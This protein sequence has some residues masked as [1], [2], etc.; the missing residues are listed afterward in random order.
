MPA[1]ALAPSLPT[2]RS[3]AGP[4]LAF[5]LLKLWLVHDR[6]IVAVDNVYD[7]VRYARMAESIGSGQWLGPYDRYTL[8]R[9][10]GYPLWMALVRPTGLPLRV[11]LELTVALAAWALA[12][13]LTLLRVPR[14]VAVAAY[15]ALLFHPHGFIVHDEILADGPYAAGLAA[16]V[17]GLA[18]LFGDP[19]P[20]VP[21]SA[22][23]GLVLAWLWHTRPEDAYLVGCFAAA[24]VL[25]VAV[26]WRKPRDW[27]VR[28]LVPA[29]AI[30]LLCLLA[31]T[32]A[33]RGLNF[34]RYGVFVGHELF[35]PGFVAAYGGLT[36]IE[37]D[38]P[39][40]YV[41][42]P[43]AS[44]T[45]AYAASPAFRT[46]QPHLEGPL[47][48]SWIVDSCSWLHVCDDFANGWF[49]FALRD[50]A[51]GSGHYV[52]AAET[53][54]FWSRVAAELQAACADGRLRCGPRPW[55]FL[56]PRPRSYLPALP[57]ALAKVARLLVTSFPIYAPGD[58]GATAEPVRALFDRVANR[59]RSLTIPGSVSV[60]G[61]AFSP[62]GRVASVALQDGD[63]R[64]LASTSSFVPR[65]D[66]ASYFAARGLP[67]VPLDTGFVL[68]SGKPTAFAVLPSAR[69]A[70]ARADGPASIVPV[71]RADDAG[72]DVRYAVDV[73]EET[74]PSAGMAAPVREALLDV[75]PR[76]VVM[77][78]AL[79]ASAPL[80]CLLL[81]LR[82]RA[83]V[84][85]AFLLLAFVVAARLVLLALVEAS[86]FEVGVRY[87]YPIAGLLTVLLLVVTA[88]A[89]GLLWS[90]LR[91][92][93]SR[94]R[95]A[96]R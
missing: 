33:V 91:P 20:S 4:C 37:P 5:L 30:P 93:D 75:H 11:T 64:V 12:R 36:R 59:R 68:T 80:V 13:S 44:R 67:G 62:S 3:L 72:P 95:G 57:G 53:D 27:I 43:A 15:A 81:R 22:L 69:L 70:I 21:E 89:G 46:L 38:A 48:Q 84:A 26:H 41:S 6:E 66:V 54:A 7:Q 1:D 88:E 58:P 86:S 79:A 23:T 31:A 2:R 77:L 25:A 18:R 19:P 49:V 42:I 10:P 28:R 82:P 9:R 39:R 56:P 55:S 92:P 47:R 73:R 40:R 16:L 45:A 71:D 94:R 96:T 76:L 83:E 63:G 14:G 61:W 17:A 35:A 51:A 65:P 50:A 90:R 85:A 52:S 87:V 74:G 32:I 60:V 24:A 78:T 34:A 8:L 29:L